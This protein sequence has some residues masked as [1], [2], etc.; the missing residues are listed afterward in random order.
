MQSTMRVSKLGGVYHVKIVNTWNIISAFS[1]YV[2]VVGFS[3]KVYQ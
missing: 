2:N 3:N 1:I